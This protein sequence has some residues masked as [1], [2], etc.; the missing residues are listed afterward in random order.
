LREG[1]I[2]DS[3]DQAN[4]DTDEFDLEEVNVQVENL[5]SFFVPSCRLEHQ[6]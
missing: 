3:N 1:N 6:V 2:W 4:I 5:A